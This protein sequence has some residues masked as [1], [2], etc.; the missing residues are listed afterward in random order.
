MLVDSTSGTCRFGSVAKEK[1]LEPWQ[2]EDAKRLKRLYEDRCSG[3]ITQEKFGSDHG[4]GTQGAVWQYL[5]GRRALNIEAAARFANGL[6]CPISDFSPTLDERI[7]TDI[8]PALG[9]DVAKRAPTDSIELLTPDEKQLLEIYRKLRAVD[10]E[11]LLLKQA[12]VI[13]EDEMSKRTGAELHVL[14][15]PASRRKKLT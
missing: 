4:I 10:R 8:I 14:R 3:A 15:R 7:R 6:R 9:W 5:N 12:T 11:S 1:P 13:L 2:R